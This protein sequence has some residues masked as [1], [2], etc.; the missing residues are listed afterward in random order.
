MREVPLLYSSANGPRVAV[1]LSTPLLSVVS[2]HPDSLNRV[3]L[4]LGTEEGFASPHYARD[5]LRAEISSMMTGDR[6]PQTPR[7]RTIYSV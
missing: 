4:M 2:G 5:E 7:E 3:T 6:L 1:V